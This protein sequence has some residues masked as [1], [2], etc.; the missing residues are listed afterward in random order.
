MHI[1]ENTLHLASYKNRYMSIVLSVVILEIASYFILY[2]LFPRAQLVWHSSIFLISHFL[3][4]LFW[5]AKCHTIAHIL[6]TASA[7]IGG[8]LCQMAIFVVSSL[9]LG[10]TTGLSEANGLWLATPFS[11]AGIICAMAVCLPPQRYQKILLGLCLTPFAIWLCS[12]LPSHI[13]NQLTL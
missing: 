2:G 5:M 6:L 7:G 4:M 1:M 10:G 11:L 9:L 3:L 13:L 12:A 8:Y